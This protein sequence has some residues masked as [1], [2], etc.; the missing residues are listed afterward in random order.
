MNFKKYV[1]R[2][3]WLASFAPSGGNAQPWV[4]RLVEKFDDEI[5]IE[6]SIDKHYAKNPSSMDKY[7]HASMLSLGCFSESLAIA[8]ASDH[9]RLSSIDFKDVDNLW[10]TKIILKWE[11]GDCESGF[12]KHDLLRRFTARGEFSDSLVSPYFSLDDVSVANFLETWVASD[13]DID[14]RIF[15]GYKKD[16]FLSLKEIERL[17]WQNSKLFDSL[18][19]EIDFHKYDSYGLLNVGIHIDQLGIGLFD[20]AIMKYM[21]NSHALRVLMKTPLSKISVNKNFTIPVRKSAGI[22]FV[23]ARDNSAKGWFDLG[24]VYQRVWIDINRRG[25]LFQPL[26]HPLIFTLAKT[27]RDSVGKVEPVFS[28]K[29]ISLILNINS[30]FIKNHSLDFER[31]SLGFRYGLPLNQ[32]AFETRPLSFRKDIHV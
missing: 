26:S 7:G 29:E 14:I 17:R 28:N 18:L 1:E 3:L 16:Y 32:N 11:K 25:I 13:P 27:Q 6:L 10:E 19:T 5:T 31:P 8:S 30:H 15:S 9:F 23:F 21:K 24:R 12:T 20:Q 22:G 4:V 2:W